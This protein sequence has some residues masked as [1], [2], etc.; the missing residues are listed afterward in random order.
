MP[1]PAGTT[2][3][4]PLT[5]HELPARTAVVAR[6][7]GPYSLINEAH[8][9]IEAFLHDE[10]L[11]RAHREADAPLEQKTCNVYVNDPGSVEP[12]RLLTHVCVPLAG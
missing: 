10:G 1:V 2:A 11:A 8:A 4:G 5:V 7:E 6:V 9:R 12:E 3:R